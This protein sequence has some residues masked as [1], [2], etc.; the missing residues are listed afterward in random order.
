MPVAVESTMLLADA[1]LR[2]VD[3]ALDAD[4]VRQLYALAIIRYPLIF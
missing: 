3:G 2:D 4:Q 1:W